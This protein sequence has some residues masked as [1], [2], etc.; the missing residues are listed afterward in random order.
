MKKGDIVTVRDSS[1][2][3][4]IVRDRLEDAYDGPNSIRQKR[5]VVIEVNCK[6][7]DPDKYQAQYVNTYNNT[8]IKIFE[9]GKIAFI[10]ERFLDLIKPT[11]EVTMAEVCAQFGENV[12]IRKE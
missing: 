8:V 9:T 2:S 7:P 4:V 11:R 12:K 1:Y 6:F 3:K 5:G 10:E